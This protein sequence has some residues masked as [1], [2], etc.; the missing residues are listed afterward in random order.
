MEIRILDLIQNC[1]TG[2]G[3]AVIPLITCLGNGGILWILFTFLLLVLKK[4]RKAGIVLAAA[5][6]INA[7]I[8]NII[9]K[10]AV[11]R[12]RPCDVNTAVNLLIKRPEDFS[13]PSGHTSAS[14][15]CTTGLFMLRIR[16]FWIPALVLSCLIAFSRMYLYV[17]YPTDVLGGI[18]VGIFSGAASWLIFR[19]VWKDSNDV[20]V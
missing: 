17:H 14:F 13:F 7:V 9:L 2:F 18:A 12:I 19:K 11:A 1:R 15:T 5:L 10:P 6:I 4:T 8:C 20:R 3:D 16:K